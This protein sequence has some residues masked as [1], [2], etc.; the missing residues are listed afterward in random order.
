VLYGTSGR[1]IGRVVPG[2][3]AVACNN[4][5]FS[6]PLFGSAKACWLR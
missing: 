6:D 5:T 2:G 4:A 1:Y 3:P